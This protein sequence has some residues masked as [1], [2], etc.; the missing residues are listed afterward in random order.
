MLSGESECLFNIKFESGVLNI[1]YLVLMDSTEKT[2]RNIIAFEQCYCT[3]QHLTN[4]MVFMHHL[5]DTPGDASLLIDER[6]IENWLSNKEA[7]MR[8][9]NNFG[10]GNII[11]P[12]YNFN[13]LGQELTNHCRKRQNKWKATFNRDYCSSPWVAISVIAAVLLL[14]LTI[15]QTVCSLISLKNHPS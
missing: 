7:A 4:Y 5:V 9:I 2:F 6:I 14:L 8:V 1:P 11:L 12:S 10:E 13:S 15:V 3:K